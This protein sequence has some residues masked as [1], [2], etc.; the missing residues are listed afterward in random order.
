MVLQ[1]RASAGHF[2]LRGKAAAWPL[3]VVAAA[4][5]GC[6]NPILRI[7]APGYSVAASKAPARDPETMAEAKQKLNHIRANY[8]EAIVDQTGKTQDA[9][10]GLVWLGTI[11]VGMA[12][13]N[14]NSDAILATSLIG[15]TTYGLSRA[16][17]DA[18]RIQVWTEGLKALDCAKE[19]SLPLDIGEA[20]R[21]QLEAGQ[22]ALNLRRAS[23]KSARDKAQAEL[24]LLVRDPPGNAASVQDAITKTD[25]ALAVADKTGAAALSLLD[26]SRGGELSV[27]VDRIHTRV[28]EAMGNVAV[29]ISSIRQLVAGVGGFASIFAP[30][31]GIESTV[32]GA[33]AS[34]DK[35]KT[36]EA[37]QQ[38]Q[39]GDTAELDKAMDTLR[40]E[41]AALAVDQ[42]RLSG[43]LKDVNLAAVSAALKK[44]DVAG[45]ATPLALTPSALSFTEK[46]ADTKG[47]QISGGTPPY[48]VAP[49]DALPE[50]LSL[51]FSGGYAETAQIKATAAAPVGEYRVLVADSGTVKRSQ[52]LV[53]RVVAQGASPPAEA[54]SAPAAAAKATRATKVVGP[55][56][57][58]KAWEDLMAALRKPGFHRD[59]KGVR[60]SVESAELAGD[61]L[62]VKLKCDPPGAGLAA[63]DVREVLATADKPAVKRLKDAKALDADFTQIDVSPS[64]SCVKG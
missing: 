30:G 3:I 15:G 58:R 18:R 56:D 55:A 25:A 40:R 7:D 34:Y 19:A 5:V 50:G 21:A 33:F 38:Q 31:A 52:Q 17:L 47:V 20:R 48:I 24:D 46:S 23:V 4:L 29:D 59:L 37:A 2:G 12:A 9:T 53:V 16:Q 54:G 6:A 45:V 63:G 28:T 57:V 44:C 13:G 26:A 49:L 35:P 43:L 64:G 27:T 11:I 61:R 41:A 36:K 8:Y 60:F 14:V 42:A 51:L 1:A 22:A 32:A 62:K 39:G 10:T